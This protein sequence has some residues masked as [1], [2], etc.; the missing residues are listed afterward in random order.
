MSLLLRLPHFQR[1]IA[2]DQAPPGSGAI[3]CEPSLERGERPQIVRGT[4]NAH[5]YVSTRER[6]ARD[7]ARVRNRRL[8]D[9][10][11]PALVANQLAQHAP[12]IRYL[13][14]VATGVAKACF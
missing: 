6:R 3:V 7:D 4:A 14:I 10:R 5:G 11:F 2:L 8:L 13:Q 9:H 12:A 1:C